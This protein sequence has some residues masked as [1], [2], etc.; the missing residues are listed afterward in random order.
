VS[1]LIK[2]QTWA[3][4]FTVMV[5]GSESAMVDLLKSRES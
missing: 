4:A 5:W 1:V 2:A 3:T